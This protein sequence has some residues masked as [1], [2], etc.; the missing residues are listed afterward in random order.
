MNGNAGIRGYIIQTLIC[1]LDALET[2]NN[3]LT[4]TLEP[5]D[6]SE[7]VDI[8]W[9]YP[10]NKL[11]VSQVKSSQNVIRHSAAKVWCEELETNSPNATDYELLL[12]GSTDKT[13]LKRKGIGKVKIGEFK[14]LNINFLIDQASTKLDSYYESKNKPKIS[15]K[16]REMIIQVLTLHFGTSSVVGMEISRA[17][18][19][20]KL[21]EWISAVEKQM[22]ANPFSTLAPPVENENIPFNHRIAKKILELIGWKQFDE[23]HKVEIFN[24]RTNKNDIH[25]IDFEGEFES[26]LKEKSG[27]FIMV[28]SIHDLQYPDTSKSEIEK[29]LDDTEIVFKELKQNNRIPLKAYDN[30]DYYSLLFWLTTETNELSKN[31]IHHAKDNYRRKWMNEEINYFLIDNNKA[32][33]LIS[34]IATAKNYRDD[35]AV[36]FLYPITEANQSP[37]KIGQRGLKLPVQYINSSVIPI[38]KEDKSKISFLLFCSDPFSTDALKKLIWL[39][40]RLTSGFGNEYL[41]YFPDF[42]EATHSNEA[43]QVIRSFNEELLDD[44]IIIKRYIQADTSALDLLPKTQVIINKN[45]DYDDSQQQAGISQKLLNEA[46]INILPYGDLLK[47]FLKTEAITANDLIY[48]L[49]K[50]GIF[51]KNADKVKLINLMATLLFS[52]NE[53]EDFKSYINIKN[54]SVHSNEE[55]YN[56][57]ENKNLD[58]VFKAVQLNLDNLTEGLNTKI[59]NQDKLKFV[60][61][62]I[63]PNEF[64]LTLITEVKD[65]TSSL[66]VNT[67]WGKSEVVVRKEN[68]KLIMVSE[69]TITREDKL[70]ANRVVK[71]LS[72]EFKRVDFIEEEKINVMFNRFKANDERVNFLLGFSN[73]ATSPVF[74]EADVQSIKFKFDEKTAIPEMYK[75]KADK[76]LIIRFEG[77]GL[78]TLQELTEQ[79]AKASIFLEEIAIVYKFDYLNIKNGLYKVTYS[80]SNAL[81]NKLGYDGVFKS[82]PFLFL[83]NQVKSMSNIE[84]LKKELS[85]EVDK[86]KL[87]KFKQ[88]NIIE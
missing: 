17:D 75:D 6:E 58:V 34:S 84:G 57:K 85:K 26:K 11:K 86:L 22:E 44:K 24:E 43:S 13:L 23:N 47:P 54:R 77:R 27:D 63:N 80:F 2:D 88:H 70:I 51:V 4:V 76:D 82:E 32:N 25:E 49:A 62:P 3:W 67:N 69:N 72:S 10:E 36:K 50:K 19:D 83:T 71:Q 39:T 66:A 41:L 15:T 56:I 81:K 38:S 73:V 35:V 14:P 48:F 87:E 30:T 12:I 28:S 45:E 42:D 9:T 33:F 40:I 65:P 5:L 79:N 21:L 1:V 37:D 8:K 59:V 20:S 74:K 31:F 16:V 60:Q 68:D 64:K 7:K 61:D 78:K 29:Y 52:P 53:L 55:F 46:F 18:F